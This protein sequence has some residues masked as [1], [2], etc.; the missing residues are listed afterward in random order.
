MHMTR[1]VSFQ[2]RNKQHRTDGLT[3]PQRLRAFV[4]L[5][6]N[7]FCDRTTLA[8]FARSS[9]AVMASGNLILQLPPTA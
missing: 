1:E 3:A 5:A 9:R 4:S 6:G 7:T 2:A 8:C